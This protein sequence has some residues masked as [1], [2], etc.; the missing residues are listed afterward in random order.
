MSLGYVEAV[1]FFILQLYDQFNIAILWT[2]S[3]IRKNIITKKHGSTGSKML[4]S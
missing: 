4:T 3:L 1:H 2:F